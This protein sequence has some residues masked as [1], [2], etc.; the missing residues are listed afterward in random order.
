MIKRISNFPSLLTMPTMNTLHHMPRFTRPI[1]LL[2]EEGEGDTAVRVES[3]ETWF[4]S[5]EAYG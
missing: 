5:I 2:F 3:A 4:E 1:R